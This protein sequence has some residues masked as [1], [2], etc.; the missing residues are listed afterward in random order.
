MRELGIEGV[1]KRRK[2]PKSRPSEP[3]TASPGDLVCRD[4]SAKR[5]NGVWFADITYVKTYQGWLYLA[6]VFDMFSRMVGGWSMGQ[7]M[8]ASLVDDALLMAVMRRRPGK[9]TIHHS[10][11]GSQYRSVLLGKTMRKYGI[12]PSM[13]GIASPWDNA[14]TESLMSTIKTECIHGRTFQSRE[15]AQM[16]IFDYIERF[17]NKLRM[18]SALGYQSPKEYEDE[19][20][21]VLKTEGNCLQ[22]KGTSR[23]GTWRHVTGTALGQ[24]PKL[25][26]NSAGLSFNFCPSR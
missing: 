16:E 25:K 19:Y 20:Y 17:Y 23:Y 4:F 22:T 5:P 18:H 8:H 10:D 9:G 14:A 21:L 15:E 12:R 1:S 11:H 13:G 6:I 3:E 24:K 7:N 2:R 26:I